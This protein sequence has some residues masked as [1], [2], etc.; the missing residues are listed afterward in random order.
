[1]CRF[2]S[3]VFI[4]SILMQIQVL[5]A[6]TDNDLETARP[7]YL[8]STEMELY[9]HSLE[10]IEDAACQRDLNATLWGL[11]NGQQWATSSEFICFV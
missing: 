3:I 11:L 6:L 1:M 10:F 2:L 9:R 4:A 5:I 8:T 7:S